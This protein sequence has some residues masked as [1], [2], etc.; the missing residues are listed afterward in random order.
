MAGYG[1]IRVWQF[2]QAR[3]IGPILLALL[4]V[5]Q[6]SS[7]F[8]AHPDYLAYFNVLAGN[9]PEKNFND[10]DIDW[11]QDL[12]RLATTLKNRRIKELAIC[13]NG[14]AD[15]DK[16]GLPPRQELIPYQKTTGWIAVS[17]LCLHT[18]TRK[19]PYD[20][21]SW[22]EAYQ[23]VEQVGKSIKLYYIPKL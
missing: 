8:T 6:I 2:R 7:S 11:G 16:L 5:W 15:L 20:Q 4:L 1:G 18:G 17:L 22:L 3:G 12:K 9:R 21:Y 10:S 13:Y 14:S 23:P 19:P